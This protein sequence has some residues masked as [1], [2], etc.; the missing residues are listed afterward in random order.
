MSI[1]LINPLTSLDNNLQN[2]HDFLRFCTTLIRLNMFAII[3]S[4]SPERT[5]MSSTS[6][7]QSFGILKRFL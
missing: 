2:R 7:D 5:W 1:N 6:L 3:L 4:A